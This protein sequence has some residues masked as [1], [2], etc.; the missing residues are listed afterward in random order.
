MTNNVLSTIRR[1]QLPITGLAGNY[2]YG[3]SVNIQN[4]VT[5]LRELA[6]VLVYVVWLVSACGCTIDK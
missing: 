1:S 6:G 4:T 5:R 3:A 2:S